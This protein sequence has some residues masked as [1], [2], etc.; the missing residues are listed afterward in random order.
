MAEEE[1]GAR[2]KL[3]DR[4]QFTN[5][6]DKASK[7]IKEIGD[8]ADKADRSGRRMGSGMGILKAGIGGVMQVAKVGAAA[9]GA[10]TVAA[11]LASP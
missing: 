8:K 9:I 7:G 11:G 2:L 1:I 10:L 4:K 3:K 5:D 6:A